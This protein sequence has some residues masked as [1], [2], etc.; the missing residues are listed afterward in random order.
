[1]A[2]AAAAQRQL[3]VVRPETS[4]RSV[5]RMVPVPRKPMPETTRAPSRTTSVRRPTTASAS[6]QKV[7]SMMSKYWLSIAVEAAAIATSL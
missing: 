3:A 7:S 5:I 1:M 2:M 6:R 4:L